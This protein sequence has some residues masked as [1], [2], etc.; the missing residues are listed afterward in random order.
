M[1]LKAQGARAALSASCLTQRSHTRARRSALPHRRRTATA[2]TLIELLVVLAIIGILASILLPALSTAKERSHRAGCLSNIHQLILSTHLYADDNDQMLPQGGT[3]NTDKNDTHTP[4][5]S[6][7][8]KTRLLKYTSAVK[9]F[10]CPNL[11]PSFERKA[12]WRT[13]LDYGVAIGYHY[14]GGQANTP[15]PILAPATDSW[16][17][18]QSMLD[19]PSSPLVADLNIYCYSFQRILAPHTSRS[20]AIRE[21]R[22]FDRDVGL[23]DRTPRDIGAQGGNVGLLDGS[24]AWKD[25][26]R[27]RTY[28]SSQQWDEAGAF[29]LW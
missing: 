5:L 23:Y 19:L 18:P 12:L 28:R 7:A 15:W 29:G 4:I 8:T 26:S 2:F 9:M 13:Q 16:I 6:T 11:S 14:L 25:I 1:D 17:S 3:D 20:F 27:M 24:A 10:D 21:E 22:D